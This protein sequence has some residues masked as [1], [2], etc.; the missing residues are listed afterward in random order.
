MS[1]R[2]LSWCC[3]GRTRC[4]RGDRPDRRKPESPSHARRGHG[5]HPGRA[6]PAQPGRHRSRGCRGATAA[7]KPGQASA[8]EPIRSLSEG[9]L[10]QAGPGADDDPA[11]DVLID[12]HAQHLAVELSQSPRA[13]AVDHCLFEASDHTESMSA[14]W[15]QP[16]PLIGIICVIFDHVRP[17]GHIMPD[18]A[19]DRGG[20]ILIIGPHDHLHIKHVWTSANPMVAAGACQNDEASAVRMVAGLACVRPVMPRSS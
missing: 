7:D 11:V 13:G 2:L 16:L 5:W 6:V 3:G 14:C 17:S 20:S 19:G 8:A 12:P 15:R 10:T 1:G 4:R 18:H 9:Q